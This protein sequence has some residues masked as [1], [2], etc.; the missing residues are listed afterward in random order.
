MASISLFFELSLLSNANM[1]PRHSSNAFRTS[2]SSPPPPP[3]FFSDFFSMMSYAMIPKACFLALMSR[4]RNAMSV[5]CVSVVVFHTART[6]HRVIPQKRRDET[7][8]ERGGGGWDD[9]FV[10]LV[11]QKKTRHQPG[12]GRPA[13]CR[14]ET[15]HRGK[16]EGKRTHLEH[17]LGTGVGDGSDDSLRRALH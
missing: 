17:R 9:V 7:R 11:R 5:C 12:P 15:K 10:V 2:S 6:H 14:G 3:E 16:A 1:S 8:R 13:A 4:S